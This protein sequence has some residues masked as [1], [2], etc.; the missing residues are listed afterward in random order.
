[1]YAIIYKNKLFAQPT[2]EKFADKNMKYANIYFIFLK[3]NYNEG[4]F[5]WDIIYL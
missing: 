1:M 3:N 2:T 4:K 5:I